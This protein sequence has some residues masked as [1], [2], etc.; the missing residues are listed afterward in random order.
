MGVAFGQFVPAPGYEVIA[1]YCKSN[2]ADQSELA[3]TVQTED[4]FAIPCVGVAVLDYTEKTAEA[5]A[6]LDVLGI[7]H[8][9][10]AILFPE[11]VAAYNLK[12]G[13]A[14]EAR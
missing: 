12:F 10:Y 5:Y 11:H 3:L 13:G 7:D 14:H 8:D 9:V 1:A 4:G 2:H 6:E